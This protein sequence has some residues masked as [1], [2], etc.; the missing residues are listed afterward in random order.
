[1]NGNSCWGYIMV[2]DKM[3]PVFDCPTAPLVFSC[4]EIP[5]DTAP[6]LTDNCDPSPIVS[7]VGEQ[8]IDNDICDGS[9]SIQRNYT[10]NDA[11]GNDVNFPCT[12]VIQ[13]DRM[14]IGFPDNIRWSCEQYANFPN[15]TEPALLNPSIIDTDPS[16]PSDIDVHPNLGNLILQNTGSGVVAH[17]GGVCSY[18]VIKNDQVI[19]GCG[20]SIEIVRTWTVIDWCTGQIILTDAQGNDNVQV[21][22]VEDRIGPELSRFPFTVSADEPTDHHLTKCVS[23]GLL[24]PPSNI[25][26]NCNS[27]VTIQIITPIGAAEYV[28]ADGS[29]GGFIPS[30]GLPGGIWDIEYRATDACGNSNSIIVPVTVSDSQTPV[31]ICDEITDVS[32]GSFGEAEVFAETFDDGSTDNCCIDR[33]E[34]RRM[35]DPCSDN[36]DDTVFG[37]SIIFCCNDV[38]AGLQMVVFRVTDCNENFNECMVQVLVSDKESPSLLSCPSDRNILSDAYKADYELDLASLNGD[39][40]AQNELLDAEFGTPIF[41]DNCSLD[42]IKGMV[43]NV[44]QCLEGR[45]TRT[46]RAVDPEGQMSQLCTQHINIHHVSDWAV[47]FPEDQNVTCGMALPDFGQPT[48]F[49][50]NCEMIAISY[51]DDTLNV[52]ANGCFKIVRTWAIINWCV[53]GDEIDDEVKESSEADLGLPL[54]NCDLDGDGDCD[55][56]TYRDSW[57]ISTRPNFTIANQSLN[58][59]TDPDSDPWDGYITHQQVMKVVDIADPVFVGGCNIPPALIQSAGC[60]GTVMLPTFSGQIMDCSPM[61][62]VSVTSD[63]PNGFGFGPYTNVP[64]GIYNIT[65]TANDNCNNQTNCS[66]TIQVNDGKLPSVF[67]H[68]NVIVTIQDGLPPSGQLNAGQVDDGSSDDCG[69]VLFSF[70]SDTSRTDTLFECFQLNTTDSIELWVTDESGN[71][72]FCRT[73]LTLID[74][75]NNCGD[76][77]LVVHINGLIDTE[78]GVSVEGVEVNLSGQSAG[79]ITTN[80]SGQFQFYNLPIGNDITIAPV[81]DDDHLNGVTTYDM[82]LVSKHILGVKPLDTPYKMIAADANRSGGITTFDLVEMRKLILYVNDEF[83][84]N[85]SWRFVPKDYQFA[86]PT[87]PWAAPFPEIINVNNLPDDLLDADFVAI[88]TGDVNGSVQANL[89]GTSEDRS[90]AGTLALQTEN[91]FFEMGELVTIALKT[92]DFEALGFQ[93]TLQF[94]PSIMEFVDVQPSLTDLGHIG[95]RFVEDGFLTVS[96][97]D[98]QSGW[99]PGEPLLQ[100]VFRAK[101]PGQIKT[102]IR[103][104]DRYTPAEAYSLSGELMDVAWSFYKNAVSEFE[105]L[106]NVPNPFSEKTTI[107]F[108]LGQATQAVLT[109]TDISGRVMK[110]VENGYP[111]GYNEIEIDRSELP[112][113]G[114]FYYRMDTSG[115]SDTKMMLLVN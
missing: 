83:P 10:G 40:A 107:G 71:Q 28:G 95:R 49:Y 79:N 48:I 113:S 80:N 96:W 13:L 47:E 58:P 76:D 59:D 19:S 29:Q 3:S 57:N 35:E 50:D 56:H 51:D 87:N 101:L 8:V 94:D 77:T 73:Q 66:T 114:I 91:Q 32:L 64:P 78:N 68:P 54:A 55:D 5:A 109:I 37:P 17:T 60:T 25:T 97:N 1:M 34:V 100:L 41:R 115:H 86:E 53:V 52:V 92:E 9:Y 6:D 30:P 16:D 18:N 99:L 81:K 23:R 62:S 21:I 112:K 14:D 33:F 84:T 111:A 102:A 45:L 26:D 46:W 110:R 65:Y 15:I 2:K 67:C 105:L 70:S 22:K 11:N 7:F 89:D 61:T 38:G 103:L 44:D 4:A 31:A 90:T 98:H 20:A 36:H 104:S 39:V 63:I 85:T 72:D 108:R 24:L 82:V 12:V 106:Q 69:N 75:G 27:D 93:F 42:L 74:P 88:K 43:I